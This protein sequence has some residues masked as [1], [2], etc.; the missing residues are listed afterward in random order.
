MRKTIYSLLAAVGLMTSASAMAAGTAV[1]TG[2]AITNAD[3]SLLAENVVLNLSAAVNGAYQCDTILNSIRV[4][5]CHSAGSRKATAIDCAQ[6]DTAADGV[7]PI[8]NDASCDGTANQTF[9]IADFR[10]YVAS[11]TGGGVGTVDLGGNCTAAAIG[12]VGHFN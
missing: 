5:T 7:T 9:D 12:G 3:C 11:S 4:G 10:G 8:Y 1:Q 2:V 6:I